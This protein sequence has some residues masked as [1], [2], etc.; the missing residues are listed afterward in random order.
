MAKAFDDE[1]NTQLRT[2]ARRV[3]NERCEGKAV[4]LAELLEVSPAFIS[5]FL[6]EKRGAGLETLSGLGRFAP[7]ELLGILGIEPGVIATLLE[8][9]ANQLEDGLANLPDELRRA[10]RA[11]IELTGCTPGDAGAAALAVFAEYGPREGDDADWW[12]LKIRDYIRL[13]PKS[14]VRRA[15]DLLLPGKSKG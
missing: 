13:R 6:N 7:L 1:I 2:L 15:T 11:A 3:M 14:G 12:L 4:R 10:A 9:R 8:G 5:D